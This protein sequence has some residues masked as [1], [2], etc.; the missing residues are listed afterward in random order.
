MGKVSQVVALCTLWLL[1]V[2]GGIFTLS[3]VGRNPVLD[4]WS[5]RHSPVVKMVLLGNSMFILA[6]YVLMLAQMSFT[7]DRDDVSQA[8]ALFVLFAHLQISIGRCVRTEGTVEQKLHSTTLNRIFLLEFCAV[9]NGNRLSLS[10]LTLLPFTRFAET[11]PVTFC[12]CYM[13][14]L[15]LILIER[16]SRLGYQ[17]NRKSRDV[18]MLR[19]IPSSWAHFTLNASRLLLEDHQSRIGRFEGVTKDLVYDD[20]EVSWKLER[21]PGLWGD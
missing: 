16:S 9:L 7:L 17:M 18:K 2:F 3:L 14:V 12:L 15:G 19:K 20:E 10:L 8:L 11:F 1:L 5:L 13:T 21:A 6:G 4:V